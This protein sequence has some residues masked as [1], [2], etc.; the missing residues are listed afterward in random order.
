MRLSENFYLNEFECKSGVVIPE[1]VLS[2]IKTL[3]IQLQVLRNALNASVTVTS[4][5]RSPE[6]NKKVGGSPKSQHVEGTAADIKVS[7]YTPKQV[8]A[9]IEE[10]I[11]KGEM[12]QGGIGIY[13]T[14]VHYDF[15]GTKARW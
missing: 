6:H 14:W 4:G 13:S 2:N 1:K 9:K 15:R 5:Y 11:E 3:A 7:G 10:L 12:K 8:A